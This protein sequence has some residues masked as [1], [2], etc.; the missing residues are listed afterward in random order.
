MFKNAIAYGLDSEDFFGFASGKDGDRYLGFRF[1]NGG[2]ITLDESSVLIDKDVAEDYREKTRPA[3]Q[4]IITTPTPTG[5]SDPFPV[6]G[7][8]TAEA[9]QPV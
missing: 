2:L 9:P 5:F 4:P 1:G 7:G 6:Y 3:P 8:S